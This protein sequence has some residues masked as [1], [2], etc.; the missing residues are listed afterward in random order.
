M[1]SSVIGFYSKRLHTKITK[2]QRTQRGVQGFC[3]KAMREFYDKITD[4]NNLI[5][6]RVLCTFVIFVRKSC[7]KTTLLFLLITVIVF[8][9]A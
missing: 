7:R 3:S 4:K 8:Y 9:Y 5:F 6:L 2:K 1:S